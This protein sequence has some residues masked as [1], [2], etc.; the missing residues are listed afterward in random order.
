MEQASQVIRDISRLHLEPKTED[1]AFQIASQIDMPVVFIINSEWKEN[2]ARRHSDQMPNEF[3]I[4]IA[5]QTDP[6]EFN[7]LVVGLLY[8]GVQERRRYSCLQPLQE[9][10]TALGHKHRKTYCEVLG[11]LTSVATSLDA[12]LYL[13]RYGIFTSDQ[14]HHAMLDDRISKL[15]EYYHIRSANPSYSWWR[16]I[17]VLNLVEYG[18]YYRRG[19]AFRDK[20]LPLLKRVNKEYV[21]IV[22]RVAAFVVEAKKRYTPDTAAET[23]EWLLQK[24]I[25][26]FSLENVVELRPVN[27]Y[28]ER[29]KLADGNYALAY[30]LVPDDWDSQEI[31]ITSTRHANYFLTLIQQ[32]LNF[33]APL[34]HVYLINESICNA[35]S[36]PGAGNEFILAFTTGLFRK[37][38]S[39][40]YCESFHPASYELAKNKYDRETYINKF[41]CYIIFYITAHE[42]AHILNGDCTHSAFKSVLC[43]SDEER[44]Q[45]ESHADRT[46]AELINMCF[47]FQYRPQ[48]SSIRPPHVALSS[49]AEFRSWLQTLSANDFYQFTRPL[50]EFQLQDQIDTLILKDSI[51]FAQTF[52]R[53]ARV[54]T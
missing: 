20:L 41:Y 19:K 52:I 18:N 53:D 16:E 34:A 21:I 10:Y 1:L 3:W 14:L 5:P 49:P 51:R 42:Y 7:R 15:R 31:L 46:A 8:R 38:H 22:Q 9:Y 13:Q 48:C 2:F 37:I 30:S 40:V 35:Y 27:T 28:K 12:E 26:L 39:H 36:N 45:R 32:S 50:V 47:I 23:V 29:I 43:I 6:K 44:H 33:K 54:S 24:F 17:E 4:N 25:K 11:K